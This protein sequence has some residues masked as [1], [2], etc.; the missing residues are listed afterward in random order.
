MSQSPADQAPP[1]KWPTACEAISWP[2]RVE[3]VDVV[4]A[5]ADLLRR[6]A[7][8]DPRGAARLVRTFVDACGCASAMKLMPLTKKVKCRRS[9]SLFISAAK[10]V[11][12][13]QRSSS[14][15]LSN[16]MTMNCGGRSTPACAGATKAA[17]SSPASAGTSFRAVNAA[18]RPK[19][20]ASVSLSERVDCDALLSPELAMVAT[21]N[22]S[23]V[24]LDC[25][26][27]R[28][29]P[30]TGRQ[31]KHD[32]TAGCDPRS[33]KRWIDRSREFRPVKPPKGMA[34]CRSVV[35]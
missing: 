16:A 23:R 24:W 10:S 22:S 11:S 9:P 20:T 15:Q 21:R 14:V 5:P 17:H 28:C 12:S 30:S 35:R 18:P 27:L 4:D 25:R 34:R 2:L 29:M 32:R 33:A 19:V 7:E 1:L 6:A 26:R 8:V 13:C 3:R 31:L